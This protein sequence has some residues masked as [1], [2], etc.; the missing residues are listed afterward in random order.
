MWTRTFTCSSRQSGLHT[1]ISGF[2]TVGEISEL[3]KYIGQYGKTREAY[4]Q[5]RKSGWD[6]NFYESTRADITLH[7]AAKNYFD[8]LGYGKDKTLPSIQSLKQE[9]ATLLAEK[10]KS[11]IGYHELKEQRSSLLVA[12]SNAD[13]ILRINKNMQNRDDRNTPKRNNYHEL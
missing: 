9:Y 3:Q 1:Q 7:K 8:K 6:V 11:Y 4:V 5:Y 2:Q 10:K 13:N 12:K